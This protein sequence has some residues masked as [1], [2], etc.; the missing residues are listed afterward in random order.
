MKIEPIIM[1]NRLKESRAAER[2]EA[3]F[4]SSIVTV[5]DMR[6]MEIRNEAS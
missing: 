5:S 1:Y 2:I 4:R 3:G 6:N